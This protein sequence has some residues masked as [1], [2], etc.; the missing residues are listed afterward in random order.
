MVGDERQERAYEFFWSLVGR[1]ETTSFVAFVND[2]EGGFLILVRIGT[3]YKEKPKR[4]EMLWE[5]TSCFNRFAAPRPVGPAP[6]IRVS[7]SLFRYV[8]RTI[9]VFHRCP[10]LTTRLGVHSFKHS[11]SR[12]LVGHCR[13][14]ECE[15]GTPSEGR[16]KMRVDQKTATALP[17]ITREKKTSLRGKSEGKKGTKQL[18]NANSARRPDDVYIPLGSWTWSCK[19]KALADGDGDLHARSM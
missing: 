12:F 13:P 8:I 4:G 6:M 2:Q 3:L 14:R 10:S 15:S 18:F 16:K 11:C 9:L 5:H 7:M 1:R 17:E 19:R